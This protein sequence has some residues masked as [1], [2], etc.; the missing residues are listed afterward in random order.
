MTDS[1]VHTPSAAYRRMEDARRKCRL[2][3]G[4]TRAVR[5]AILR[6]LQNGA[7]QDGEVDWEL[8]PQEQ[9]EVD[10]NFYKR[11]RRSVLSS[12]FADSIRYLVDRVFVRPIIPKDDVPEFI[13]GTPLPV[14]AAPTVKA[15]GGVA[16]AP[17][18]V[19]AKQK[20]T[21]GDGLA[22]NIDAQNNDITEFFRRFFTTAWR[23]GMAVLICDN[24]TQK[25]PLN[26]SR[27]EAKAQ[28]R[29]YLRAI[30]P[31]AIIKAVPV[32][33]ENG[34]EVPGRIQVQ[35][36]ITRNDGWSENQST[37]MWVLYRGGEKRL[38]GLADSP[39]DLQ[40]ARYEYWRKDNLDKWAPSM[41][42]DEAPGVMRP[43]REIPAVPFYT[44]QQTIDEEGQVH[45]LGFWEAMPPLE[46]L[47]DLC[48][49]L[50]QENS[51]FRGYWRF[52]KIPI[53][54]ASGVDDTDIKNFSVIAGGKIWW[55]S[56]DKQVVDFKILESSG[57]V[58]KEAREDLA[59]LRE[60]I[61]RVGRRPL[62]YQKA[63]TLGQH[64][65]EVSQTESTLQASA[66]A[67][68][69]VIEQALLLMTQ[70]VQGI[71]VKSGGSV[72]LNTQQGLTELDPADTINAIF[73][74]R[75]GRPGSGPDLSRRTMS[76]ILQGFQVYPEE[77]DW[78]EEEMRLAEEATENEGSLPS[79]PKP[80]TAAGDAM[81]STQAAL[82]KMD[83]LMT[84]GDHAGAHM[85]LK[86]MEPLPST[87]TTTVPPSNGGGP[88]GS[89]P[90]GS[91]S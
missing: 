78:E 50:F 86:T 35:Q 7:S 62:Q 41:L 20:R 81:R 73:K 15:V 55:T 65:I 51:D 46:E 9:G 33:D 42:L 11:V 40:F 14:S 45:E 1:D 18:P 44:G 10:Q 29:P 69:D 16:K 12:D 71:D 22:E 37:R 84:K 87:K 83:A 89:I 82:A 27:A 31:G 5:R 19:A 63:K 57:A 53:I 54:A 17:A 23:E 77:F 60:E 4:G 24:V 43:F 6:G 39:E 28:N 30:A 48:I 34:N 36:K 70:A 52:V 76:E 25:A 2:L 80:V 58:I 74:A 8:L 75:T 32:A 13:R 26:V 3:F 85:I 79:E 88:S 56:K 64:M 61:R 67:L 59:E 91:P 66:Q 49:Q 38:S 47:A 21:Q 90:G 72:D 68:K